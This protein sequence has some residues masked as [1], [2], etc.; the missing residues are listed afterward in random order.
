MPLN[1]T[2]GAMSAKG[3]GFSNS[4]TDISKYKIYNS[5]R[6]R[7]S[8]SAYLNRTLITPTTQNIFT[9]S[10]WVKRGR[11]TGTY[12]L[13]G[14]TNSTY[15]TFNSSDQL[16]LT[17]SAVSAATSTAVFR[18]P[19]AWYHIVYTQNGASQ[20]IY[21]NNVSVATG[22]TATTVFNSAVSHQIGASATANYFDGYMTEINFVD[23]QALTPSSFGEN[24]ALTGVWQP[25]AY[26][27]TYGINGFYLK[28]SDIALTSGS[29]TGLGQDFSGNG[30]Y[31]NTN[32][33]SVT[34]GVTY[35][36][37]TDVPTITN[38]TTAN[39]CVLNPISTLTTATLSNANIAF[40]TATTGHSAIG[41]IGV[42]SGKWYWEAETSA[43]TTQARATVYGTSASTY[44]SFAANNTVYGFRFDATAGTLDYTTDGTSWIS[45]ATGLTSGPYFPYFNN[46]GVTSKTI[47]VN[48]GQRPFTYTPPTGYKRLNTYNLA[49]ASIK[50]GAR[51]MN[52]T[53]YTGTVAS[54]SITNS[55]SFQPDLVWIKVRDNNSDNKLTD[56]VR[57]VTKA[58][59]SQTTNAQTTDTQG[60]T[61][62]NSDGFTVGTDLNYNLNTYAYVSWQWRASSGTSSYNYNGSIIS[63]T[64]VNTAAGFSI[65]SYTGNGL[66]ATTVGHGLGALPTFMIIKSLSV[67]DDWAVYHYTL[68]VFKIPKLNDNF[69]IGTSVAGGYWGGYLFDIYTFTLGDL[70][71]T[72]KLGTTY[73]AYC[74]AEIDGYSSMGSYIGN[75]SANGPFIYTGFRPKFVLI[76]NAVNTGDWVLF[77][78]SRN[79]NNVTN[80]QLLANSNGVETTTTANPID[81]LSNGFK[82]R[83][84]GANVNTSAEDYIYVAFAEN[85]FKYAL[86]R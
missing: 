31:W 34:A 6:F 19:S 24:N 86:A 83:G 52:A 1:I 23:G 39:Y 3:F 43:G 47:S 15:L 28:F 17:L 76:R 53:L 27:G 80:K 37:M 68:D 70:D 48:F 38:T 41:S 14:P 78:S 66:T 84:V 35:D 8:A 5:L 26:T 67:A 71:E 69:P 16:N 18:D 63:T 75:A 9:Y 21:V 4:V 36:A 73:I 22:T 54:Q 10:V 65:V 59:V 55:P 61:A 82:I 60:L 49:A 85:P 64:S 50:N 57:G 44:Y 40:T 11:L 79:P 30:N 29:N 33:I 77:D 20:T 13:F 7:N 81:L 12:R 58:I 56:S 51:Y 25:K 2:T 62:F 32:N 45:L 42:S 74:W 72:N 46:N